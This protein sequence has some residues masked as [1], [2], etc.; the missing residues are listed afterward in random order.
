VS[1]SRTSSFQR[2][3]KASVVNTGR[4]W[5]KEA[6]GEKHKITSPSF[7]KALWVEEKITSDTGAMTGQK[8][9]VQK[10]ISHVDPVLIRQFKPCLAS[11]TEIHKS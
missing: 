7:K 11:L 10:Y 3:E 1:F 5:V 6:K 9:G 2:Q 8:K 4:S